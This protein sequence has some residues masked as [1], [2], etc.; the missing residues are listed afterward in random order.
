AAYGL[1][2]AFASHFAPDALEAAVRTYRSEFTPSEQLQRPHV[3]AAL[4]VVAADEVAE[5]QR[6]ADEVLRARVRML[7]GRV[8]SGPLDDATVDGLMDS[9]VGQQARHMLSHTVVGDRAAVAEGLADFARL[10]DADELMV[11]N[12]AA[13]LATRMRTLEILAETRRAA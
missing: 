13:D 10:A 12:P 9:A 11:T 5:A 4:N 6:A 1:P 8:G 2:Y 7:A 3:I